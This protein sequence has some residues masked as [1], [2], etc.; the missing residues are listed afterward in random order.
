MPERAA[1]VLAALREVHGGALQQSAFGERMR[2]SGARWDAIVRLFEQWRRKLGL[3]GERLPAPPV[4]Q[5]QR[6]LFERP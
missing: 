4:P 2:G 5:R 6:S 3:H 1:K